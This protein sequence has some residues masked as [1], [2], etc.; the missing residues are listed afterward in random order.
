MENKENI[1]KQLQEKYESEYFE[2][3]GFIMNSKQK[4]ELKKLITKMVDKKLKNV[5][6]F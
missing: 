4:K 1:I 2:K 5:E 3:N 6:Q